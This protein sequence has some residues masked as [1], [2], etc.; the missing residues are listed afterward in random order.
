[1]VRSGLEILLEDVSPLAKKRIGLITNYTAV[2][3]RFSFIWDEFIDRGLDLA[4]VFSPEHGLFGTEQDQVPVEREP[5][6]PFPVA[7]LYGCSAASLFPP[8]DALDDISALVFDIQDVGA[9]YYT[10]VNTMVYAMRGIQGRDISFIVLDRPNPI[11]GAIE[12]PF[13]SAGYESFVGVLPVTVRHGMTAGELALFARDRFGLDLDLSVVRMRGWKRGMYFEE[14]GLPWIPPSPNMPDCET[15]LVYPG[16]CLVEGMNFSEGRGTATP[17]RLTGAPWIEPHGFA[18]ALNAIGLPGIHFVPHFFRPQFNK[19]AGRVCGGARLHVTDRDAFRPFLTGVA[20]VK[21][22]CDLY[23]ECSFLHGVY[24]FNDTHPAFDLLA[25][26]SSVREMIQAGKS[27]D[28][29]AASWA[30][31]EAAFME[32]RNKYLLY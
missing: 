21:T 9:R 3:A 15:A 7:S 16:M 8:G 31:D 29:I 30:E 17:F 27:I 25:G 14:T 2:S 6:F 22:A 23:P 4:R 19:Y 18:R 20:L 11:G 26:N 5:E 10:F 32:V 28:E 13:L 1:M 24:E 12:G